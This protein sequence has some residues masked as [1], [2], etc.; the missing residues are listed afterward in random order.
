[1]KVF[2]SVGLTDKM[3][4][5]TSKCHLFLPSR[6]PNAFPTKGTSPWSSH[7][8][9]LPTCPI[10]SFQQI[11]SRLT[12]TYI[13]GPSVYLFFATFIPKTSLATFY[14]CLR[15]R[16]LWSFWSLFQIKW[17]FFVSS[18]IADLHFWSQKVKSCNLFLI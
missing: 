9:P 16:F 4:F 12:L 7:G 8:C 3:I 17:L 14:P 18:S 10:I 6:L 11:I 13:F 1:M 5:D 2:V 15:T